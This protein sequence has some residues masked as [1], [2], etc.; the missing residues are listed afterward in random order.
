MMNT[1]QLTKPEETCLADVCDIL[2][3]TKV[4]CNCHS[5]KTYLVARLEERDRS[6][7]EESG[8]ASVWITEERTLQPGLVIM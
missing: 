5:Q 6:L 7:P 2:V 1:S 3:E 4:R 8:Y